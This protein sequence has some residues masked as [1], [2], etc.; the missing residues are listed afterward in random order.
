VLAVRG[1]GSFEEASL[2]DLLPRGFGAAH[3]NV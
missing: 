1:D 2:S 3:L